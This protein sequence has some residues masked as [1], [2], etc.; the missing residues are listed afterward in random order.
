M[1][2]LI[3]YTTEDGPSQIKLRAREQTVWL[4]QLEMAQLFDVSTDNVGLHLKNIFRDGELSR[5]ATTEESSVVQMRAI[6]RC[7]VS[8]IAIGK[9]G[10]ATP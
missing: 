3:L 9:A 8:G 6:Q 1:N 2:D 10:S 5:E 4:T 7:E